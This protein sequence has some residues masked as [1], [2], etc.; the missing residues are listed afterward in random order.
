MQNYIYLDHN[1][2]TPLDEEVLKEMLPYFKENFFN[3]SA[4]YRPAIKVKETIEKFR[5]EIKKMFNASGQLIFTS[6][7]SE[8]VNLGIKGYALA[9]KHLGKHMITSQ[10]EHNSVL[11]SFNSLEKEGFSVDAVSV[12]ENGV[13]NLQELETK[14]KPE[15][16]LISIMSANNETGVIQPITKIA[17]IA[18]KHEIV[19]HSDTVQIIGKLPFSIKDHSIDMISFSAHKF[20]GPKGVGGLYLKNGIKIQPLIDGG[21]Q[22]DH[23]RGGTENTPAIVGMN[24]ALKKAILSLEENN[25][26]IDELKNYF[27][28]K[29]EKSI[30]DVKIIG[31]NSFRLPGTS[32]ISF[33]YTNSKKIVQKLSD[34]YIYASSGSACSANKKYLSHVLKAMKLSQIDIQGTVRFSLGKENTKEQ[35]D[36]AIEKLVDIIKE[37]RKDSPFYEK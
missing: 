18:K 3:A 21:G 27:E 28:D 6:G 15:T 5:I 10:I 13:I 19:F 30:K 22:E 36:I 23:L 14:I 33:K 26:K 7:G 2:T 20:Y 37:M 9:H 1:A 32:M 12:D 17:E 29:I 4:L 25:K 16:I 11:N 34:N 35:L 31:K 8:S 24:Q